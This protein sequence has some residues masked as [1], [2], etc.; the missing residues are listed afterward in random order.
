LVLL[1]LLSPCKV[2]N[3]IQAELDVPQTKVLNKSQ[4]TINQSDCLS[5]ELSESLPTML[6]PS[7]KQANFPMLQ[8]AVSGFSIHLIKPTY[9]QSSSNSQLGTDVPLY[10]LYQNLQVYS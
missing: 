6:E 3:H 9:R 1:L 2:R 8:A 4:S 7:G 10:I 5:I